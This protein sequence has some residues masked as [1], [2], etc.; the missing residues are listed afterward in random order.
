MIQLEGIVKSFGRVTAVDG[1]SMRVHAGEVLGLLG[2]N[3]AGKTTTISIA[4]GL[5][6]PDAGMARI[7]GH[8]PRHAVARKAIGIA[9]QSLAIY[10]ELTG[11]ENLRFFAEI[12]GLT[13]SERDAS[14]AEVLELVGLTDR[15][16]DRVH[17]Y[18]G[19]MKRR[20]NLAAAVLHKPKVV[21]MDEPTAGVDPQSRHAIFEIVRALKARGCTVVYSTHYM[22]E[23]EKLCDRLVIVDHGKVLATGTSAE[24][25]G[26]HGGPSAVEIVRESGTE[27]IESFDPIGALTAAKGGGERI[28]SARIHGPTLE[29]VFLKLTGRSLRD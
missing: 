12:Y 17:G 2:P 14:V 10:D 5:I 3:G 28:V 13:G 11:R 7:D 29:N 24:L 19:G 21:F 9:P 18:S 20:L 15:Q 22:E 26:A 23:A 4:T 27:R 6:A 8:D 25:I 16:Q 1:L